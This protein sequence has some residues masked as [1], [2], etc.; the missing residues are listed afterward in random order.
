MRPSEE[1]GRKTANVCL[2]NC[3]QILKAPREMEKLARTDKV[4]K[5]ADPTPF[6]DKQQTSIMVVPGVW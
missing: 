4:C 3:R 6:A 1:G 2:K 5:V